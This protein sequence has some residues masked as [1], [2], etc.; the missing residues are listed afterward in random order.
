[1]VSISTMTLLLVAPVG[2]PPWGTTVIP[3]A[4]V[5]AGSGAAAPSKLS[6]PVVWGPLSGWPPDGASSLV[7]S[8]K[9][10][11][12]FNRPGESCCAK[13]A[14]VSLTQSIGAAGVLPVIHQQDWLHAGLAPSGCRVSG[15]LNGLQGKMRHQCKTSMVQQDEASASVWYKSPCHQHFNWDCN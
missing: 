7:Q 6:F 13:R 15:L 5:V 3:A 11:I 8:R 4:D 2:P 12:W 14:C 10:L 1:M 9:E